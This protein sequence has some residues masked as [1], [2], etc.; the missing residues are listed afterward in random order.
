MDLGKLPVNAPNSLQAKL[1]RLYNIFIP[2]AV[3]LGSAVGILIVKV[4][5]PTLILLGLLGLIAFFVSIY[6]AEFGLLALAFITYTRFSDIVVQ[7]HNSPSIAKPFLAMLILSIL[8]RWVIFRESP[9]GW[10]IPAV[11]LGIYGLAGFASLIYSPVPDRVL[12]GIID[13]AKDAIIAIVVVVLLQSRP[14]FRKTMWTLIIVGIFLG[15]LSV[16]QYVTK[17]YDNNYGGFAITGS[18]QI[19]GE[20]DEY[21]VGGPLEDPNFFSQIMV[22]LIPISLERFFHE[23]RM[24]LKFLALLA[25]ALVSLCVLLSYSRGGFLALIVALG[26]YFYYYPP[27]QWQLLLIVLAGLVL[28]AVA[29]PKY[30]DRILTLSEF[31]QPRDT[32]RTN[33][34]SFRG[35]LSENLAAWEM[36]KA[37]P[38]FGVGLKSYNYL[39]PTYSKNLGLALVAGEREAHNLY[40]EVTAETGLVGLTAFLTIIYVSYRTILTARREMLRHH[41]YEF[42]AM[43]VGFMAGL[44]G[45]LV[46]ATFIHGAYPRYFYFL[47]GVALSLRQIALHETQDEHEKGLQQ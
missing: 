19:V 47:I 31:F 44:T 11:L 9:K 35:R 2:V 28:I 37:N 42:A 17:S 1:A 21:R 20:D 5:R 26:A 24:L 38:L 18:H 16:H 40:L 46:A 7:Y 15:G 34:L 41:Q 12:G 36:I 6:S 27:R 33:E 4:D 25:V 39:F 45:Y 32:L 14:S 8:M 30:F 10:I 23:R 43:L 22:V 3:L 29:P 13:Y